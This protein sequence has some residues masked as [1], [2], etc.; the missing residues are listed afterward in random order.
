[1]ELTEQHLGEPALAGVV[2]LHE[3]LDEALHAIC[4]IAARAI[5]KAEGATL[6]TFSPAGPE[7]AAAS[8]PCAGQLDELQ[9]EERE[10]PRLDAA[11]TGM[12]FRVR[13]TAAEPRWPSYTPRARELGACSLMS[14]PMTVE[15]KI[16]GALNVY[17]RNPDAFTPD[18]VSLAQVIAGQNTSWHKRCGW[19]CRRS[20]TKPSCCAHSATM[21]TFPSPARPKHRRSA[22]ATS[23]A[24]TRRASTTPDH[25][26]PNIISHCSFVRGLRT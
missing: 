2:L 8:D 5:G 12:L 14:I 17:A 16:I 1:L 21:V 7:V 18:D 24:R 3:D 11:R 13:D 6:T 22:Y 20:T 25:A 15:A 9:Y 19:R 26:P 10:G 4:S 23:R